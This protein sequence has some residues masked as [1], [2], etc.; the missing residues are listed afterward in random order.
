MRLLSS[1]P[2][3]MPRVRW[4]WAWLSITAWTLGFVLVPLSSGDAL[5]AECGAE[6]IAD[7]VGA[8]DTAQISAT[9][10]AGCDKEVIPIADAPAPYFT[11]EVACSPDR[12]A[13]IEGICS[14]TPMPWCRTVLCISDYPSS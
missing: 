11:Y 8:V 5:A 14:T 9:G 4:R 1:R 7:L 10:Q 13:A 12:Q 3:R 6:I 2:S